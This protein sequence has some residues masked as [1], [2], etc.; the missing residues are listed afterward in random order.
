MKHIYTLT[1]LR[2]NTL[3]KNAKLAVL[4]YPVSHS[5]SPQMHQAALDALDIDSCYIRLEL[6]P[7]EIKEAFSL[8]QD[9]GFL[10]CNVTI[11]H[12]LEAR[13]HSHDIS[14]S[15]KALGVANTIHFKDGKI[16]ADNTDGLGLIQAL[17]KDFNTS[18]KGSNILLLGGGGS[19]G[20]AIATQLAKS[21]CDNLYL[22]NRTVSKL[23]R[24][25]EQLSKKYSANIH[26]LDNS[27]ETLKFA[28]VKVDLI[29]NATSL[30]MKSSDTS[31]LPLDCLQAHHLVYD[32]IYSPPQ[33]E[34]LKAAETVGAKTS[35]GLSMLIYQ[36]AISFQ[37]WTG[38][39]PETSLMHNAISSNTI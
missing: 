26:I 18:V 28:T 11:P 27:P 17:E 10:G 36:G 24:L 23:E 4:G 6:K 37:I 7:G 33:T 2:E 19:A 14:D 30:G 21:G 31:P 16:L 13:E 12:K 22:S 3:P 32:A 34:L 35:N 25:K 5:A 1:D 38:I 9:L 39:S 8:M 15:V 20:K 29:V